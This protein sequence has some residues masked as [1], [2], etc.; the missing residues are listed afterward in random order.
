M[1]A[2]TLLQ[3]E[4]GRR[5]RTINDNEFLS[6]EWK[7]S[8][9]I[10]TTQRDS[11]YGLMSVSTALLSDI[12]TEAFDS[13]RMI[14]IIIGL[15]S[16]FIGFILFFIIEGNLSHIKTIQ[17]TI[18]HM[19]KGEVAQSLTINSADEIGAISVDI[20]TLSKQ[21]KNS[22]SE[23]QELS[24]DISASAEEMSATTVTFSDNA[25]SQAA[26]AER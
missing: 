1:W 5:L 15:A 11:V 22:V 4:W 18:F 6:Y 2:K 3:Y 21:L 8:M 12:E 20:N 16:L 10:L 14:V 7:G 25:Q 24:A 19:A 13:S 23:I 9:K 17:K 26:S